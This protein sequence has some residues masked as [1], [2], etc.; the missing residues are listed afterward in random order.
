MWKLFLT[1]FFLML[2]KSN[3]CHTSGTK[4]NYLLRKHLNIK[5]KHLLIHIFWTKTLQLGE[6]VLD[7]PLLSLPGSLLCPVWAIKNMLRL[8]LAGEDAALFCL[9]NGNPVSSN[10]Y[11]KFLKNCIKGIGLKNENFSTHYFCR[12]A[13]SLAIKCGIPET[14]IQVMGDWKSDSYKM[15]INCLLEVQCNFVGKFSNDLNA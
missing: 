15:Y 1:S 6:K 9:P 2:R 7:M 14:L 5:W 3:V 4:P 8:V 11:L 10:Y 13:V 12:G